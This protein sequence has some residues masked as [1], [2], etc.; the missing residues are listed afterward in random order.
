MAG[1]IGFI[2][3]VYFWLK[4]GGTPEDATQ[5]AQGCK[6]YLTSIPTVL[7]L[8]VGLP[9]GTDRDVVDNSYAVFLLVEFQDAA[10]HDIYQDH[11]EH[12][13]FIE[14]CHTLWSKVVVYDAT[15]A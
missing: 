11:P 12:L 3:S 15:V 14:A 10:G 5:L 4:E 7:R 6:T 1:K 13:R 8:E 9:A 2:H